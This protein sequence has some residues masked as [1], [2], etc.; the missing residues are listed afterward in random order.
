MGHHTAVGLLAEIG[1]NMEQFLADRA[2]GPEAP[3]FLG[4]DGSG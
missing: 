1:T 3:S 4:G 2:A